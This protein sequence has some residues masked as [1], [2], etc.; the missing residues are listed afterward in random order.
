MTPLAGAR[1]VQERQHPPLLGVLLL[2]PLCQRRRP[3]AARTV[4]R[5]R[6]TPRAHRRGTPRTRSTHAGCFFSR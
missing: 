2:L 4:R 6:G 1:A 3:A 5:H